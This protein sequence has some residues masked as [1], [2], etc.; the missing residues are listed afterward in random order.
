MD[1][2]VAKRPDAEALSK[3]GSNWATDSSEVP[4]VS[5]LGTLLFVI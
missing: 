1:Q 5:V 2:R 4:E 3:R